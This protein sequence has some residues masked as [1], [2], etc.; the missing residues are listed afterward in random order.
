MKHLYAKTHLIEFLGEFGTDEFDNEIVDGWP[1]ILNPDE[2]KAR[3]LA[4]KWLVQQP[5]WQI[6][7]RFSSEKSR[8]MHL[9]FGVD[10][11]G[12]D[13]FLDLVERSAKLR[14]EWYRQL[15]SARLSVYSE[16]L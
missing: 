15:N 7:T 12:L 1:N 16:A 6:L 2:I 5:D 3:H 14:S 9:K 8:S 13:I 4:R 11:A 10:D